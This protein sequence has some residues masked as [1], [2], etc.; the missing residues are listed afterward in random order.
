MP[1]RAGPKDS[2]VARVNYEKLLERVVIA[3]N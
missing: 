2:S 1:R 3:T